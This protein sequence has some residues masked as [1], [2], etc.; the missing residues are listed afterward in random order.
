MSADEEFWDEQ[1]TK[2]ARLLRVPREHL[3]AIWQTAE[4]GRDR[5]P[6]SHVQ[7][8]A[9]HV[10]W[11]RGNREQGWEPGMFTQ[12]LLLAID[13]ADTMNQIRIHVGFPLLSFAMNLGRREGDEAIIAWAKL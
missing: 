3:V 2:S 7:E 1:L 13:R 10:L 8:A 4:E 11:H 12:T 5:A 6:L 9:R